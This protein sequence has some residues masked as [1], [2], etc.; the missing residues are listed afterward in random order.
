M[1]NDKQ[2]L[3]FGGGHIDVDST[4][5]TVCI[6]VNSLT[7]ASCPVRMTEQE[8]QCWV[9]ALL[10]STEP[11]SGFYG[12]DQVK[13]YVYIGPGHKSEEFDLRDCHMIEA[14]NMDDPH[15]HGTV[16]LDQSHTALLVQ[17]IRTE[18]KAVPAI[19]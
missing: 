3:G 16:L 17:K 4:L 11:I 1:G 8:A 9:D 14:I 12:Y 19:A 6:T 13:Y 10:D 2:V 5:G 15:L 7:G 18:L